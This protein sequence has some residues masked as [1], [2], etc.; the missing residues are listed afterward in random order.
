T[1]TK[2][3]AVTPEFF[4]VFDVHP[5]IGRDFI[6]SDDK[7]GAAPVA[8]V[9]HGYWKQ[10]IGASQDLSQSH[11]KINN[12]VY[13]VIGVIPSTFRFP[14]DVDVWVAAGIDGENRSRTSHNYYGVGRLKD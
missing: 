6:E 7:K 12:A 5:T 4:S 14:N 9:S 2:V 13:S 3:A 8:L 10:Y 1:R 11:L